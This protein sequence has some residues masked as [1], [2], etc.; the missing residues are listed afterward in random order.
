MSA[1]RHIELLCDICENSEWLAGRTVAAVR[2]EARR[3]GWRVAL[4][5]SK[6]PQAEDAPWRGS[7]KDVCPRCAK[8]PNG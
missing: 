7:R 5:K 1:L 3:R 6:V 4:H 8:Q 2:A